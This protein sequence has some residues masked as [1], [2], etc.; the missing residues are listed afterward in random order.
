[1]ANEFGGY[2]FGNFVVLVVTWGTGGTKNGNA[3]AYLGKL[4]KALD[5]LRHYLKDGP[6][7]SAFYFV[8]IPFLKGVSDA[9]FRIFIFWLSHVIPFFGLR[10][11]FS[12]SKDGKF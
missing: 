3:R 10:I 7:V 9:F 8:P 12:G 5:K 1:M 2:F 4:I 6:G 11:R